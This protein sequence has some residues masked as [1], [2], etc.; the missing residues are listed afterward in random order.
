MLNT[1]H[2]PLFAEPSRAQA[3]ESW[4]DAEELVAVRWHLFLEARGNARRRA[5]AA[6]VAALD[7]EEAAAFEMA[8]LSTSDIAA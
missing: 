4:R 1:T 3:F 6:Y 8:A 5:F 7:A 2:T